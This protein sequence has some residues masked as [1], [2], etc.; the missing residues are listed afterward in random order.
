M[1]NITILILVFLN[2]FLL[3]LLGRH[4]WQEHT[5]QR[6]LENELRQLYASHG[7]TLAQEIDLITAPPEDLLLSR[8]LS[9]EA[10]LADFLLEE[11]VEAEDQGGGIYSYSGS[12]GT[13][14]FRSSG[15][16]DYTPRGQADTDPEALAADLCERFGYTLLD[17]ET[18]GGEGIITLLQ[19]TEDSVIYNGRVTILLSR[20]E[21]VSVSGTYVGL[22]ES[23]PD[24]SNTVTRVTAL[25]RF[26]DYSNQ[27]GTICSEVLSLQPVYELQT[28]SLRLTAK[29]EIITDTGH[30]YVD[31]GDGSILRG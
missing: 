23:A 3:G 16:F 6:R 18:G 2:L 14:L 8:D 1:K 20:G 10:S 5:S 25:V 11:A 28:T 27:S 21:V 7:M 29:W 17:R 26:L 30:Y 4:L 31:C 22:R 13:V 24:Q 12:R 9:A 15:A 19:S